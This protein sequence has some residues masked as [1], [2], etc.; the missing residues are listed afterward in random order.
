[1]DEITKEQALELHYKMW[2]EMK[3]KLG[4]NCSINDRNEFKH[5]WCE[6]WCKENGYMTEIQN[7]CFLCEYCG[8]YCCKCPID[9]SP[10]A[11]KPYSEDVVTCCDE[12]IRGNG[13]SIYTSAPISDILN[14]PK[15]NES[16]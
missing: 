13:G 4:N 15:N 14:L 7:S 6:K 8:M 9:W 5:D 11:L 3:D 1:M 16:E 10:L 2:K 12:Y